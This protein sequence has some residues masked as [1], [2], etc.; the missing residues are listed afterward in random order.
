SQADAG[1]VVGEKIDVAGARAEG[2][3]GAAVGCAAPIDARDDRF[4]GGGG[5]SGAGNQAAVDEGVGPKVFDDFD[6]NLGAEAVDLQV[7]GADTDAPVR[8]GARSPRGRG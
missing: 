6:L 7:L 1:R 3:A 8:G 5:V 4:V 2:Y